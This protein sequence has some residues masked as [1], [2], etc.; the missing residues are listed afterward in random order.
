MDLSFLQYTG[1]VVYQL[2]IT[3][4]N[5]ELN[6]SWSARNTRTI[7][8]VMESYHV[9]VTTEVKGRPLSSAITVHSPK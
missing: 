3:R 6:P 4:V 2:S 8:R 1:L 5:F 7:A 9:T